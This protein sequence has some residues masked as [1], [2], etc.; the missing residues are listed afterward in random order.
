MKLLS[1]LIAAVFALV[2]FSAVAA[3]VSTGAGTLAPAS[4]AGPAAKEDT[5]P[6]K[7]AHYHHH[8]KKHSHKKT[9]K[10]DYTAK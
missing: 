8:H 5:K 6:A 4:A 9:H 7:K 3:D 10:E 1:T 2:T